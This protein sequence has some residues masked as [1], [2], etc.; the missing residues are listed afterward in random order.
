MSRSYEL[1]TYAAREANTGGKR[2][3]ETGKYIGVIRFAFYEKNDKGTESISF[4]FES[5]GGQEAGPL[6]IYTHNGKGEQ[7]GGYK[8]V[9]AIMTCSGISRMNA[10]PTPVSLYDY[11]RKEVV[12]KTKDVYTEFTNKRIG[13]VLQQEEYEKTRDGGGVGTRIIIAA[14][15]HVPTELMAAEILDK[16]TMP[17]LLGK[18]MEYIAKNPVR[19]LRNKPQTSS[20]NTGSSTAD[21]YFGDIQF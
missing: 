13:F 18:Y 8:L 7:L 21:E 6:T 20:Q 4:M 12:V 5:D 9:N 1:D 15:F 16:K 3:V 10:A 2:I 17:D 14:P 11:D 19:K